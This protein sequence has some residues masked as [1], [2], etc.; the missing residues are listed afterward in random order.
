MKDFDVKYADL[1]GIHLVEANAGTG[2]TYNISSLCVRLIAETDYEIHKLLVLTFTEAATVELR[3]RIQSR[4]REVLE[5]LEQPQ[6]Q[7]SVGDEFL[8]HCA[9]KYEANDKVM[10]RLQQ[11]IVAF[12]ESQISTIHSFCQKLLRNYPFQF[13]VNPDF[14]LLS[15]P[16]PMLLDVIRSYWRMFFSGRA[17]G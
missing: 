3:Q 10:Y 11:A 14:E 7:T 17:L 5:R 8:E 13:G 6:N 12:D 16:K 2:K 9:T 15:N 4:C 1:K